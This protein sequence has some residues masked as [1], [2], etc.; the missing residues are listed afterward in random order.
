MPV[1]IVLMIAFNGVSSNLSQVQPLPLITKSYLYM[2][3][4][5]MMMPGIIQDVILFARLVRTCMHMRFMMD[6]LSVTCNL[7]AVPISHVIASE[8]VKISNI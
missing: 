2:C 7:F 5:T 3:V 8:H 4:F 1:V 6:G